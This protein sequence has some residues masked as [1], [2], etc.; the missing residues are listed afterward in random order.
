MALMQSAADR[1]AKAPRFKRPNVEQFIPEQAR[2]AVQ[3]VVAAGMKVMYAPEMRQEIIKE[4][5]SDAPTAQK[6]AESVTGLMLMLDRK[7]QGGIPLQAIFPAAMEL[8]GEAGEVLS[9]AGEPVT[10]ADYNEAA[11][12]LFINIGRKLGASDEQMMGAAQQ[13]AGSAEPEP[14]EDQAHESGE[15]PV[16][17]DTEDSMPEEGAMPMMRGR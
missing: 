17:E 13:A 8:L 4:V 10:Q 11:Q 16:K 15:T 12:M 2:D 9:A 1:K 14:G 6:M 7:S 3:R 5:Q